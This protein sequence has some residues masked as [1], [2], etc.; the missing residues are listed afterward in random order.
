MIIYDA[1]GM[2]WTFNKDQQ[3]F[4]CIEAEEE[5]GYDESQ[6]YANGYY[7]TGWVAGIKLINEDGY[8]DK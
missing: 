3:R 1:S 6:P 5:M 7:C 2:R 4:Y 8:M